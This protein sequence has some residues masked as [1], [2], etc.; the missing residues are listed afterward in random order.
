MLRSQLLGQRPVKD[1]TAAEPRTQL[2]E[3]GRWDGGGGGGARQLSGEAS[4]SRLP[5]PTYGFVD[6]IG[7][8]S[9]NTVIERLECAVLRAMSACQCPSPTRSSANLPHL[10]TLQQ[11]PA[12]AHLLHW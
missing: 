11:R 1:E 4:L 12:P 6:V 8:L 3:W 5:L 9:K 7:C 10:V 2:Q